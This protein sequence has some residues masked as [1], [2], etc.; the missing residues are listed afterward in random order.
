[1][2]PMHARV[3][4]LAPAVAVLA[5]FLALPA[6]AAAKPLRKATWLG[7]TT[8]T[9]YYPVP[10]AW[11][12]GV[13]VNAPGL[14]GRHRV[15]WLYSGTGLSMEGDGV[16][17]DGRPYHIADTGNGGWVN[18]AGKRTVPGKHGW[19]HGTPYWLAG[20]FWRNGVGKLTFPLLAGG[21]SAGAGARYV[22]LPGVSFAAGPSRP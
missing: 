10:E 2:P 3:L 20:G 9:E 21:W 7:G 22:P 6:G 15:D 16:G 19:S 12:H 5:A 8:I 17:L 13:L 14:P 1:M 11:F 4:K 18:A